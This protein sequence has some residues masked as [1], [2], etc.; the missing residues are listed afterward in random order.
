MYE[1]IISSIISLF[2]VIFTCYTSMKTISKQIEVNQ[3]VTNE[4]IN[5][6]TRE[7]REHNNFAKRVPILEEK[8]ARLEK[9]LK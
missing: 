7:V 6:L 5:E 3:A 2:G 1:N 9:E 4:K 8:V